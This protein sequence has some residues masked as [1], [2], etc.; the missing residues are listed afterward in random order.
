[1]QFEIEKLFH[2]K[3]VKEL[4]KPHAKIV[5]VQGSDEPTVGFSVLVKHNILSAPCVLGTEGG[6]YLGF[7]EMRDCV[8]LLCAAP[9]PKGQEDSA[10]RL[11]RLL[12]GVDKLRRK[13][14]AAD[15]QKKEEKVSCGTLAA[16]HPMIT[17]YPTDPLIGVAKLLTKHR[18][19]AVLNN[20]REKRIVA[21]IS[22]SDVIRFL[23]DHADQLVHTLKMPLEN[24]GTAPVF[25]VSV[26][27]ITRDVFGVMHQ[28][29]LHGLA[30]VD[31]KGKIVGSTTASDLKLYLT[32][33]SML[34][35]L[36]LRIVEY[37]DIVRDCKA[38]GKAPAATLREGLATMGDAMAK[39]H[40]MTLHR[41][42][43]CDAEGAP[44]RV[45]SLTDIL[46]YIFSKFM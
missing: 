17:V 31:H 26:D 12:A 14:S 21:I 2:G 37:L 43:L 23:D 19:V 13:T 15:P 29:N 41:I 40:A 39:C 5:V 3:L 4:C 38:F 7:L 22:Q 27:T 35:I 11:A 16:Q 44:V 9:P 28:L 45:L 33:S 30:V 25:S 8:T 6:Y 34:D 20:D 1:M 36:Q 10:A 32:S 42:F 18:R 24:I 46:K